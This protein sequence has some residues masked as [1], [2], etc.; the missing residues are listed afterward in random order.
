MKLDLFCGRIV[1]RVVL[2][3]DESRVNDNGCVTVVGTSM[4]IAVVQ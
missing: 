2:M 4:A 3:V 1:N